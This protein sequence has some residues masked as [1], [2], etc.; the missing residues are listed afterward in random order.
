MVFVFESSMDAIRFTFTPAQRDYMITTRAFLLR[1]PSYLLIVFTLGLVSALIWLFFSL[2]AGNEDVALF[3]LPAIIAPFGLLALFIIIT[4][5]VI[6]SAAMKNRAL[7]SELRWEASDAGLQ[8]AGT[9]TDALLN[10]GLFNQVV[11]TKTLFSARLSPA[12][13]VVPDDPQAGVC[14]VAG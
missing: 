6:A 3:A 11:E 14:I 10:W 4:P 2:N 9:D 5:I 13:Q 12:P 7:T 8:V 1:Q